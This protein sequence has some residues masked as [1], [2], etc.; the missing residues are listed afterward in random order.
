VVV[1]LL[2]LADVPRTREPADVT[3]LTK[4]AAGPTVGAVFAVVPEALAQHAD[5]RLDGARAVIETPGTQ[6]TVV[7][8][9]PRM[10]P[11]APASPPPKRALPG[12]AHVHDCLRALVRA[13]LPIVSGFGLREHLGAA[14]DVRSG[15][16]DRERVFDV[17]GDTLVVSHDALAGACAAFR[18]A[19]EQ[20]ARQQATDDIVRTAE[21]P[22][23]AHPP[24]RAATNT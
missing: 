22:S 10:L 16:L 8:A 15:A 3:R 19:N 12:V 18:D 7:S 6:P 17:Q 13:D 9:A 14:R 21:Q 20:R 5:P 23:P 4:L 1:D 2:R 24:A 11:S